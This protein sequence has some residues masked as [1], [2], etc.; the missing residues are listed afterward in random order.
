MYICAYGDACVTIK[1]KQA[2]WDSVCLAYIRFNSQH[3]TQKSIR[4]CLEFGKGSM[5]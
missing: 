4:H 2:E 5:E 1:Q 3:D